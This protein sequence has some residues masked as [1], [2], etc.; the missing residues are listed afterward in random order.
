MLTL[1]A[2][3]L[4]LLL[5]AGCLE[6]KETITV[7]RDGKVDFVSD[8]EGD[9][10]DFTGGDPLPT[11]ELG[12]AV[13]DSVKKE[14][15]KETR[16]RMAKLTVAAG[17]PLP[18]AY[19]RA[20]DPLREIAL[21]FPT[22]VKVEKRS[23]G[24]YYHFRRVYKGREHARYA[25]HQKVFQENEQIKALT[26]KNPEE[27]TSDERR[28]ILSGVR[29]AE[30]GK[31]AEFLIAG[32]EAMKDRWPQHYYLVARETLLDSFAQADLEPLVTLLGEP[33]A[34]GRDIKIDEYSKEWLARADEA[35]TEVLRSLGAREAEIGAFYAA[36]QKEED[37]HAVTEDLGDE[38]WSVQVN[39]PGELI[40]HNA[41]KIEEGAPI[42]EFKGD[43]L[44]DRDQIL[45]ATSRAER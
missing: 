43:G 44:H 19:V 15:D 26:G 14:D 13:E 25:V 40:A 42:W 18:D 11:D 37:R 36:V 45:M 6:R 35:V 22:D 34:P 3:S 5:S 12:W 38:T 10:G 28:L 30:A 24:V 41:T 4:V 39:L 8:F 1:T 7:H 31:R 21:R 17:K 2:A 33:E 29:D 20:D 16:R 27:L 23:D 9:P 32:F